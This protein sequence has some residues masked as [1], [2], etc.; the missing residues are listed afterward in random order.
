MIKRFTRFSA[1]KNPL[2]NSLQS[3]GLGFRFEQYPHLPLNVS[4]KPGRFRP[5]RELER[6]ADFDFA[7][8]VVVDQVLD[9]CVIRLMPGKFASSFCFPGILLLHCC[10]THGTELRWS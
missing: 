3:P 5:L 4:R 10:A 8:R 6:I 2:A 7:P 1:G 9:P